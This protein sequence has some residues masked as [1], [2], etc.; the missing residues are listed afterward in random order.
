MIINI[1]PN[2]VTNMGANTF[3]NILT[4]ILA[5]TVANMI[6]NIVASITFIMF[7]IM[8][9]DIFTSMLYNMCI[10]RNINMFER[11]MKQLKQKSVYF[12]FGVKRPVMDDWAIAS[13]LVNSVPIIRLD[14]EEMDM[15]I[16]IETVKKNTK[17]Y[18]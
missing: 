10:N 15:Y 4:I 17:K 7:V 18:D 12:E 14:D 9:V 5:I 3:V 1:I 13:S 8:V 16:T 11:T 2:I 6:T